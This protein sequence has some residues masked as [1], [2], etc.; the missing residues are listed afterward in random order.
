MVSLTDAETKQGDFFVNENSHVFCVVFL[1]FYSF[2]IYN[3]LSVWYQY[4][5]Q[6]NKNKIH[7]RNIDDG[8]T[9]HRFNLTLSA[10]K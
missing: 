8:Y 1:F 7:K 10:L 4:Y 5:L 2:P 9:N 3:S 6:I